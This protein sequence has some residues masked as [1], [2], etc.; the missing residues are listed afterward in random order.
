MTVARHQAHDR[1]AQRGIVGLL[2]F[3]AATVAI[4]ASLHLTGILAGG[5]QPFAPRQAGIAEAIICVV[6]AFGAS[7][8]MREPPRQ[9]IAL[10]TIAVAILGFIVGLVF[11]VQGGDAIDLAFHATMLP[12]LIL[13]LVAL[14]RPPSLRKSHA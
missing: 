4:V 11:T 2:C 6:L 1:G 14:L 8:L 12:L 13:T 10:G 9:Q 5:H 3:E 7:T